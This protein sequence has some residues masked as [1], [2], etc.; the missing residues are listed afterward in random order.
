MDLEKIIQVPLTQCL[1]EVFEIFQKSH[2]HIA[3]VLD[4][5]GGTA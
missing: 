4:E 3:L 2:K 1:D 5:H